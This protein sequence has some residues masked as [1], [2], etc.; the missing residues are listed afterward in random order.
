MFEDLLIESPGRSV[1]RTA[2]TWPVSIAI[3]GAAIGMIVGA[4]MWFVEEVPEPPIPVTFYEPFVAPLPATDAAGPGR[5]KPDLSGKGRRARIPVRSVEWAQPDAGPEEAS[6]QTADSG[7]RSGD[8][9]ER[10]TGVAG[11]GIPGEEDSG[12]NGSGPGPGAG[13]E[14]WTVGGDVRAPILER[15][16]EP[17][18][19]ESTRRIGIQGVV[20]LE[21]II[22]AEGRVEDVRVLKSVHPLLDASAIQAVSGWTYRPATLRGRAVRVSL[23]VTVRFSLH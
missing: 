7:A 17:V 14:L 12:G 8:E 1:S 16:I 5:S 4:S 19:P 20:L 3:H 22:T 18:Y 21:A 11:R 6:R 9:L 10:G 23:T 15:R 2:L 13:E